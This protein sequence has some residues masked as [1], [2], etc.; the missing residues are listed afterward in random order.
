[1]GDS[2]QSHRWVSG[3]SVNNRETCRGPSDKCPENEELNW[4]M[5]TLR[6]EECGAKVPRRKEGCGSYCKDSALMPPRV[7]KQGMPRQAHVN[8]HKEGCAGMGRCM[9]VTIVNTRRKTK[10]YTHLLVEGP[11]HKHVNNQQVER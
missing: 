9:Q 3:V 7:G 10:I 11:E 1:M 4:I 6:E 8:R 2:R 5:Y